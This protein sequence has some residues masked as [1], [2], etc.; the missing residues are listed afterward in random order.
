MREANSASYGNMTNAFKFLM[1]SSYVITAM[2][3]VHCKYTT[4]A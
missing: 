1:N 4:E 3:I 2:Y